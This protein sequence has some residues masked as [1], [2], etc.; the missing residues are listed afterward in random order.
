MSALERQPPRLSFTPKHHRQ[1]SDG[2]WTLDLMAAALLMPA[3][4]RRWSSVDDQLL[5]ERLAEARQIEAEGGNVIILDG[6]GR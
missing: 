2:S 1:L 5:C 3:G 6:K 4:L